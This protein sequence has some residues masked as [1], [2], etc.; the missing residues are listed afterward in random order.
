MGEGEGGLVWG[1]GGGGG[2]GGGGGAGGRGSHIQMT[3][4][5][6]FFFVYEIKRFN[7][8]PGSD[9]ATLPD[10]GCD[11]SFRNRE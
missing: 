10:M 5:R 4:P 9:A 7:Y 3:A 6:I 8:L 11:V 1:G 2:V